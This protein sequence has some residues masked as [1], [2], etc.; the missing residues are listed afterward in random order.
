MG[1]NVRKTFTVHE[2]AKDPQTYALY[3]FVR[4]FPP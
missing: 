4:S 3:W 2:G 1:Q